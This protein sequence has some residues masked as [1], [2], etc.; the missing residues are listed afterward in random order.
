[1]KKTY[2]EEGQKYRAAFKKS[3]EA[4]LAREAGG[5][6]GP[7]TFMASSIETLNMEVPGLMAAIFNSMGAP[8][9]EQVTKEKVTELFA[10]ADREG[11]LP[12]NEKYK[13]STLR[14]AL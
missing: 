14:G 1:M 6:P 5:R 7:A 9:R 13:E 3:M 4:G 2:T 8:N 10:K 12:G 11:R